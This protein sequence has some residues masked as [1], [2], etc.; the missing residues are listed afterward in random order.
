[1]TQRKLKTTL[2]EKAHI[3]AAACTININPLISKDIRIFVC[4]FSFFFF[5]LLYQLCSITGFGS[6]SR[7]LGSC[8]HVCEALWKGHS[9]KVVRTKSFTHIDTCIV[10]L[11]FWNKQITTIN[12][13]FHTTN[14]LP[15][16]LTLPGTK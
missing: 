8:K 7:P 2:L 4:T 6:V 9:D 12:K 5:F 13:S 10:L 16:N 14:L 11:I 15:S 3:V 1:M